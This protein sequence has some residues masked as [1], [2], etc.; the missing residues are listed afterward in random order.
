MSRTAAASHTAPSG[1]ISN[2]GHS[3]GRGSRRQNDRSPLPQQITRPAAAPGSSDCRRSKAIHTRTAR[4]TSVQNANPKNSAAQPIATRAGSHS[5]SAVERASGALAERGGRPSS[6]PGF[7]GRSASR[8]M[9]FQFLV[10]VGHSVQ[11]SPIPLTIRG[12]SAVGER[13]RQPLPGRDEQPKFRVQRVQIRDRGARAPGG[14]GRSAASARS[15][16]CT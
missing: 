5:R 9:H 13:Q 14:T 7:G 16:S 11:F 6:H 3:A 15:P 8:I 12:P 4:A 2:S 10:L 1:R